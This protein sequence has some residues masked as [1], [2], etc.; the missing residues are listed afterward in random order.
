[1]TW[2]IK[3]AAIQVT[4]KIE[5]HEA[6]PTTVCSVMCLE[7]RNSLKKTNR[8]VTDAYKQ[9][10]KMSVGIMKENETFLYRSSREPNAGEVMYWLPV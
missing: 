7:L 4:S 10:R 5:A 1:M 9:P 2:E 8:P 3:K 6:Q